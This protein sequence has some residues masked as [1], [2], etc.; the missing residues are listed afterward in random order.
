MSQSRK[1]RLLLISYHFYPDPAVGARRP[2]QFARSLH[3]AGFEI[4]VLTVFR[5]QGVHPEYINRMYTVREYEGFINPAWRYLKRLFRSDRE[6]ASAAAAEPVGVSGRDRADTGSAAGSEYSESLVTRMK[7][8]FFSFQALLSAKKL[9]TATCILKL[10][11]LRL[12]GKKYG[13]VLTSSPPACVNLVGLVARAL[14]RARWICDLRDPVTN[15]DTASPVTVTGLRVSIEDWLEE[16]YLQTADSIVVTTPSY[17][18][19]LFE[20]L[21][22]NKTGQDITLLYNGFDRSPVEHEEIQD[23]EMG[24]GRMRIVYAGSL[25]M[26]RDPFPF[27]HAIR[28]VI[29]KVPAAADRLLVDFYGQCDSF[30]NIPLGKWIDDNGLGEN[31]RLRGNVD[32]DQL[33]GIYRDAEVLLVFA[34]QQPRQIPAKIFE[35]MPYK[36]AILAIAENESDTARLLAGI[37]EYHVVE[38]S[39]DEISRTLQDLMSV[40][41]KP[42]PEAALEK[43]MF[44]SRQNQNRLLIDECRR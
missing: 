44:Y 3:D 30:A 38:S 19:A 8:Y 9:W 2:V 12:G 10:V 37:D 15:W 1:D 25:Y 41:G 32:A 16:K 21:R 27:L 17:E 4:D 5:E 13:I 26:N 22:G 7:R 40:A 31:V 14:F 34:Q 28:D 18:Q 35:Y 33:D 36:T 11:L 39:T 29:E 43:I 23:K 42:F 20:G 6:E 24:E